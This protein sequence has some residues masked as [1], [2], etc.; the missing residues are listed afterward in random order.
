MNAAARLEAVIGS[1]PADLANVLNDLP[2]DIEAD[3]YLMRT[4]LL[5][6]AYFLER[7]GNHP[8]GCI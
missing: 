2:P 5:R 8:T 6:L 3:A 7:R 1:D 4:L